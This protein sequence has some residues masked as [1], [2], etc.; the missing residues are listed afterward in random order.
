M[1]SRA[2]ITS[3]P[4]THVAHRVDIPDIDHLVLRPVAQ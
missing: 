4:G 1:I 2:C 3:C